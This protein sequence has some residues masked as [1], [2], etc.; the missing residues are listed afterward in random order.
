MQGY[1]LEYRLNYPYMNRKGD[2][3]IP[4]G[5]PLEAVGSV[6]IKSS[7]F[8]ANSLDMVESVL[9]QVP[10]AV[11]IFITKNFREYGG[12][13]DDA[14]SCRDTNYLH[15]MVLIG[16]GREDGKE[17]WL[18][19]N[20]FSIRWGVGG[21]Y[22][23]NKNSNCVRNDIVSTLAVTFDFS[24]RKAGLDNNHKKQRYK[25]YIPSDYEE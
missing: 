12:G 20:S 18:L 7:G 13:V 4:L 2:C 11:N 5:V 6:R 3:P 19:R 14:I 23:L 21:H 10:T 24:N 8:V 15:A 16:T 1:G 9:R 25:S 17:Y 22:K